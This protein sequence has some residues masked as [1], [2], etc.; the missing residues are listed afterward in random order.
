L[1]HLP[2]QSKGLVLWIIE[3]QVLSRQEIAYLVNLHNLE[4]KVKV[5]IEMG[6]DRSFRW[7]PLESVLAEA[8]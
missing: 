6:G 5:V 7:Q 2:P 1:E 4:P 3:G 8:V